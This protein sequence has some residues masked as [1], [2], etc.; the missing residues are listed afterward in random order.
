MM[1]QTPNTIQSALESIGTPQQLAETL[2]EK[3][4]LLGLWLH[5]L[6]ERH[7]LHVV[8]FVDQLEELWALPREDHITKSSINSGEESQ[9]GLL[10]R[11]MRAVST[12]ADDA[13][14]PVR[15]ILTLREEFISV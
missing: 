15:V 4:Q 14:L 8:L 5:K 10:N 3:P 9:G 1:G 11:F 2:Y 6:A 7:R 12:A 13:Q